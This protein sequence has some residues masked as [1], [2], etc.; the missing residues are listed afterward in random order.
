[1]RNEPTSHRNS[2]ARHCSRRFRIY[3][4]SKPPPYDT[5]RP[6]IEPVGVDDHIRPGKPA[7]SR[8]RGRKPRPYTTAAG[9]IGCVGDGVLDVPSKS[10]HDGSKPPSFSLQNHLKNVKILHKTPLFLPA[11]RGVAAG[12]FCTPQYL[13]VIRRK[14]AETLGISGFSPLFPPL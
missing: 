3:G 6:R 1:M 4:G 13:V 8:G 11:F 9:G 10:V 5:H 2:R 14:T 12:C 7:Q